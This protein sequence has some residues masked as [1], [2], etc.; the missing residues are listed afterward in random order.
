MAGHRRKP[1]PRCAA[2]PTSGATRRD[3][4]PTP[5]PGKK[6]SRSGATIGHRPNGEAQLNCA[7]GTARISKDNDWFAHN[8]DVGLDTGSILPKSGQTFRLGA[9]EG[10]I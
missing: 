6:S 10:P 3:N 1:R 8:P 9:P 4:A 2:R 5:A 7:C